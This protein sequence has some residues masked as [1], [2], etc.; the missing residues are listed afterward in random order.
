MLPGMLPLT[1]SAL[2]YYQTC[3]REIPPCKLFI[4]NK[5]SSCSHVLRSH[6]FESE[7]CGCGMMLQVQNVAQILMEFQHGVASVTRFFDG[8]MGFPPH[9]TVHCLS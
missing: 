5:G 4:K 3:A 9:F 6:V 7:K 1:D 8:C 2:H